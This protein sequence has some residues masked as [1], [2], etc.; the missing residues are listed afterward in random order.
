LTFNDTGHGMTQEVLLQIFEPFFSTKDRGTGLGLSTVYGIVKQSA[1]AIL[2][3][4]Q[5]HAGTTITFA[6]ASN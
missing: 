1:G 5:L 4:S 6:A 2:A 3:S